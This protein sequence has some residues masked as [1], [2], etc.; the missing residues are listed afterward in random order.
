MNNKYTQ[1]QLEYI[2]GFE[3]GCDYMVAEIERWL[4]KNNEE[5][6]SAWPVERLLSHLKMQ[7]TPSTREST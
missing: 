4:E 6:R 1:E 5:P 3:H 7:N 2:K